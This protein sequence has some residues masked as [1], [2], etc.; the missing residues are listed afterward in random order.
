[1]ENIPHHY[2]VFDVTNY[3]KNKMFLVL[4]QIIWSIKYNISRFITNN[5]EY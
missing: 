4:S 3:K 2:E 1:M 5:I